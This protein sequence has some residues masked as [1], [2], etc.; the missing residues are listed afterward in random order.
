MFI[1][2][3][4]RCKGILLRPAVVDSNLIYRLEFQNGLHHIVCREVKLR[5]QEYL[6][7][8]DELRIDLV[9]RDVRT[10]VFSLHILDNTLAHKQIAVVRNFRCGVSDKL[11]IVLNVVVKEASRVI[12]LSSSDN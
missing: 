7:A 10:L 4:E 6:E 11:R 8:V 1:A 9:Y 3:L 5:T 2:K 12:A